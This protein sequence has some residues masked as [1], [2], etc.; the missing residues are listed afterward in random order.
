MKTPEI[1]KEYPGP[2]QYNLGA[3]RNGVAFTLKP[4]IKDPNGKSTFSYLLI[5]TRLK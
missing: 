3:K 2:A 1:E 5:Q 4:K